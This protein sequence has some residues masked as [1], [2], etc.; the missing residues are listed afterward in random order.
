M[1]KKK[2]IT[3]LT[4]KAQKDL[5]KLDR[6]AQGRIFDF[7]N[8]LV[9]QYEGPREVGIPLS[10]TRNDLWRYRVGDYRVI[11]EILDHKVIVLVLEIGHRRDIYDFLH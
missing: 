5:R 8:R 2:W 11:C 9:T 10:G 1:T 3:E 6:K 4:P 7:F